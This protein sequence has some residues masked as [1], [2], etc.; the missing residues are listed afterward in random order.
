M[1]RSGRA[2]RQAATRSAGPLVTAMMLSLS[3]AASDSRISAS[4]VAGDQTGS[5]Q[6]GRLSLSMKVSP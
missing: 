4:S 1:I 2:L 3:S 6:G 5:A